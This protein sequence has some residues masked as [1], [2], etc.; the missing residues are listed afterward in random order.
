LVALGATLWLLTLLSL[1][2]G[3][4]EM[5]V[6]T[7]VRAFVANDGSNAHLIV[8]ELRL[9]RTLVGVTVGVALGLAGALMQ[10][11][12]RNPLAE[13]GILGINAGAALAVVA[14]IALLGIGDV[15]GYIWF[16]LGGAAVATLIV[17]ALGSVGRPGVTPVRLALAGAVLAAVLGALTSAVLIVDA[18]TLD[19]FR[20]WVVGSIAGRD[21]GSLLVVLPFIVAGTLIVLLSGRTLNT[22]ALGD[23]VAR[24]LGQRVGLVRAVGTLAVALLAGA[25]VAIAGPIAF[26]GLAAP[27]AARSLVGP[28]YRWVVAWSALLG[29][30]LILAADI[31]G[32]IVLRPGEVE[33]GIMTALIGAPLLIWLVRRPQLAEV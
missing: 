5:T 14:A 19:Q 2:I 30:C 10:A 4:V 12:T 16:A 9:P 3:S 7:V 28:D 18:R 23:D 11:L 1:A 8:T 25:A 22:L 29:A 32:R 20:F 24:S 6:E 21:L 33:V 17:Y 31:L 26:V 15:R 27:H 13:P